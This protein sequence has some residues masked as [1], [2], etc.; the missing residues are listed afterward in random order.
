MTNKRI[1]LCCDCAHTPEFSRD[2]FSLLFPGEEMPEMVVGRDKIL[3]LLNELPESVF[4]NY[5]HALYV[6]KNKFSYLFVLDE[7]DDIIEQWNLLKGTQVV[8]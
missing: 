3:D 1:I 2:A 8:V 7:D 6:N 4:R 5:V